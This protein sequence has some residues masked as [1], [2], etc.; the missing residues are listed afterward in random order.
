MGG[1]HGLYANTI[2]FF[3]RDLSMLSV[4]V[5]FHHSNRIP[6]MVNLEGRKVYFGS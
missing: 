1:L 3:M 2:P 4:L 6:E 5:I